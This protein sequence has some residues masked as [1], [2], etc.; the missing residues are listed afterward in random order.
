MLFQTVMSSLRLHVHLIN[1]FPTCVFIFVQFSQSS[2]DMPE[3]G[4]FSVDRERFLER[5]KK[6]EN[7]VD[8]LTVDN[9]PE[10]GFKAKRAK[11]P[12][13]KTRECFFSLW[14]ASGSD[15]EI[16]KTFPFSFLFYQAFEHHFYIAHP[17]N[18]TP[19]KSASQ[20]L[21]APPVNYKN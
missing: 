21:R 2:F 13:H 15:L 12:R 18:P 16:L 11:V 10:V 4:P 5:E 8:D 3:K 6:R 1:D 7:P 14:T 9:S 17:F 20:V 19:L